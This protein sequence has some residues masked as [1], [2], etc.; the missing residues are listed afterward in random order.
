MCS[1]S[2]VKTSEISESFWIS[3]ASV[4]LPIICW[5]AIVL[6]GQ[7][8]SLSKILIIAEIFDAFSMN[9]L[10]SCP[11]PIMPIVFVDCFE[12]KDRIFH[13]KAQRTQRSITSKLIF[14]EFVRTMIYLIG[15]MK[16]ILFTIVCFT[17]H[18][19]CLLYTSP[20]PRDRTRYRMPSSA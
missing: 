3:S 13:A 2:Q 9:I 19:P 18:K 14:A 8:A 17:R 16:M 11:P 5:L 20:S 15:V 7:V 1:I 10:P 4:M 12:C 6:A